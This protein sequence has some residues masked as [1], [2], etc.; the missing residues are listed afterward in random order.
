MPR[1]RT[2]R[3]DIL[4]RSAAGCAGLGLGLHSRL[5][6]SAELN[7]GQPLA[8]RPGHFPA[9]AKN[10]VVFFMTGGLSHLDTFD[11][12]PLL[13][14]DHDKLMVKGGKQKLL[15]SPYRFRPCGSS[16]KM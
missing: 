8:P 11:D 6:L 4:G 16:G 2:H 5:S 15:G 9:Q 14:R 1:D 3:R 13:R 7:G 12:K 10:L